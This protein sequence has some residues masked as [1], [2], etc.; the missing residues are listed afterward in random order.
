VKDLI[1]FLCFPVDLS[2][3]AN[4]NGSTRH[5]HDSNDMQ[6]LLF[7]ASSPNLSCTQRDHSI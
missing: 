4:A 7:S 1:G 5:H 2:Y 6:L 3:H